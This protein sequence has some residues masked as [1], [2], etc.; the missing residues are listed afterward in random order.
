MAVICA[1]IYCVYNTCYSYFIF[2]AI[3]CCFCVTKAKFVQEDGISITMHVSGVFE[4]DEETF[5]TSS[6]FVCKPKRNVY[7]LFDQRRK[8]L[9]LILLLLCGDIEQCPGPSNIDNF[10]NQKG[11]K[12]VHQNICGLYNKIPQLEVFLSDTGGKIDILSLSKPHICNDISTTAMDDIYSLPGYIFVKNNREDGQGGGVGICI[13]NGL[14]FKLQDDK[15]IR[16]LE[17]IWIEI[18]V[19]KSKSILFGCFY[20]P[21]ESSKY[22]NNGYDDLIEQQL[23]KINTCNKE[24]IIMGDFNV[25]YQNNN[26]TKF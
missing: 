3:I 19:F 5:F 13:K 4:G 22:F 18:F 21:P 11:L 12:F 9:C 25:N 10:C 8:S 16:Y 20:R 2:L 1:V 23:Q 6:L 17:S 24:V 7:M 26:T 14:N 15:Q